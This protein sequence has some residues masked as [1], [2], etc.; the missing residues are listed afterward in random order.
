M[1][2]S[3]KEREGTD[4]GVCAPKISLALKKKRHHLNYSTDLI[5]KLLKH[6]GISRFGYFDLRCS[7]KREGEERTEARSPL[8]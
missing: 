5:T 2:H 8:H 6:M 7:S 3:V 1:N 4:V